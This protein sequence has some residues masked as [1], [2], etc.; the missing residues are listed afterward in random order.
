VDKACA[1]ACDSCSVRRNCRQRETL[2]VHHLDFPLD[3]DCRKQGRL[4]PELRRAQEQR[5]AMLADRQRQKEYREALHQQYRFLE[6]YL[7]S[8]A[9]R[10]PRRME[11]PQ[12]EFRI[13]VSSR[14]RSKERTNADIC[15][16]FSGSGCRYFLLLCDG[17]GTGLSAAREGQEAAALLQQMLTAGF[18]AE[19]ALKTVNSLLVL[20]GSGGA[21]T[22][23]LAEVHLDTGH[24]HMY[25]WGAAPSW[26]LSR[27]KAE[28]IGTAAPPPGLGMNGPG[29]SVRKLSLRRGEVLILVSDG[30]EIGEPLRR[31]AC[32]P[33]P[34]GE[35]AEWLLRE[36]KD[37]GE[38]DATVAV[39]R[40]SPRQLSA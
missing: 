21:V 17:M 37:A 36:C 18:P 3:A 13:E 8:L 33:W 11:R 26:L 39:L 10:L 7:R 12:V 40:L 20:R 1:R 19:H 16:A 9:D 27:G 31:E 15:L 4:L 35:L 6:E 23:D 28:K 25:K 24:V 2:S 30:A 14:S 29:E 22:V 5:K 34:P 32:R 38:D